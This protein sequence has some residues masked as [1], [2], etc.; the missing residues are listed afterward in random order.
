M[1]AVCLEQIFHIRPQDRTFNRIMEDIL[2]RFLLF[3]IHFNIMISKSDS[4]VK[5]KNPNLADNAIQKCMLKEFVGGLAEKLTSFFEGR[6]FSA[7]PPPRF[8]SIHFCV[9]CSL[10]YGLS[11]I[12]SLS[13]TYLFFGSRVGLFNIS[14]TRK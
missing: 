2:K 8:F 6:D 5:R 3:G 13:P 1:R 10:N 11:S 7:T 4:T 14:E 12:A 9:Y